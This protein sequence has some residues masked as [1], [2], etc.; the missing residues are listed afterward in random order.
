M[1][2]KCSDDLDILLPGLDEQKPGGSNAYQV[3]RRTE[4]RFY[5]VAPKEAVRE[6]IN[7]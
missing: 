3:S 4:G 1:C 5:S 2:L 7:S 6:G